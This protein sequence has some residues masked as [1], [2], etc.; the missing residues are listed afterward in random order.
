MAKLEKETVGVR[1]DDIV[2]E[3]EEGANTASDNEYVLFTG[4]AAKSKRERKAD[5][6]KAKREAAKQRKEARKAAKSGGKKDEPTSTTE[7]PKV[8]A[9]DKEAKTYVPDEIRNTPK[10]ILEIKESWRNFR[11]LAVKTV[12][13]TENW[14]T[15]SIA[16]IVKEYFNGVADL[17]DLI[18]DSNDIKFIAEF[19]KGVKLS[20]NSK[21]IKDG[22][23]KQM[24]TNEMTVEFPNDIDK[25]EFKRCSERSAAAVKAFFEDID[26]RELIDVYGFETAMESYIKKGKEGYLEY[27]FGGWIDGDGNKYD[28][29]QQ[30]ISA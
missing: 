1:P 14:K 23:W 27:N 16:A 21:E 10:E 9:S 2:V 28:A 25:V 20:I 5:E 24:L 6:K 18:I 3:M 13:E 4:Q 11:D 15:R 29:N 30:R 12:C 7:E 8:E 22:D 19:N 17:I 26:K